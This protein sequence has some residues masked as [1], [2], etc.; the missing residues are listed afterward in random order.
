M[1]HPETQN[2]L[3]EDVA[4][5]VRPF[6]RAEAPQSSPTSSVSPAEHVDKD[7]RCRLRNPDPC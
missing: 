5:R 3:P 2:P 6:P 1:A 7:W 4:S